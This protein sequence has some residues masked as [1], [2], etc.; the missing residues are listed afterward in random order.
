MGKSGKMKLI[1]RLSP[2]SKGFKGILTDSSFNALIKR[3]RK[4][5]VVM[6][7]HR[8]KQEIKDTFTIAYPDDEVVFKE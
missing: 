6:V 8:N 3:D 2:V 4:A 1:V 7:L 5:G